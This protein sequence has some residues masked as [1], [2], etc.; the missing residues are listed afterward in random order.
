[1]EFGLHPSRQLVD[2]FKE[3]PYQGQNPVKASILFLSSDANYSPEISNHNFFKYILEYQADG[4]AF[5]KKH[6]CH[7]PFLLHNYPFHGN[8]HGRRFHNI[9]SQMELGSEYAEYISFVELLDVP[10]IGTKSK[11]LTDFYSL[12]SIDHLKYLDDLITENA[13]RLIFI[14]GG[15]LKNMYKLNKKYH[16]HSWLDYKPNQQRKYSKVVKSSH[17]KEIYHF[18][19]SQIHSQLPTI[20][21]NIQSWVKGERTRL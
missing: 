10:T 9:F 2:L 19:S 11:N 3:R 6:N 16:V 5:W 20:K 17:V 8:K 13:S 1:M 4:V 12:V 7:H 18:S 21:E 14:S 15:V